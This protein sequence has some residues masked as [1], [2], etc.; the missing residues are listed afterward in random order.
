MN[1]PPNDALQ[2]T[3]SDK[4]VILVPS[5]NKSKSGSKRHDD[6]VLP[7]HSCLTKDNCHPFHDQHNEPY[8]QVLVGTHWETLRVKSRPMKRWLSKLSWEGRG[9]TVNEAEMGATIM[10][11]EALAVH[12]GPQKSLETRM[13]YLH[14]EKAILYDL[15]DPLWRAVRITAE[16]QSIVAEP[17]IYFR[18]FAH[19]SAQ[20]EP[21][22]GGDLRELLKLTNLA[23]SD[24]EML[25]LVYLVSC[26][27]PSIPHPV[28][29]IHGPQGSAKT[30]LAKMARMLVD[31]SSMGALSFPNNAREL[32]Q[33][34]SHNYMAF[35]DNVT[36]LKQEQSDAIC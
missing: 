13:F 34:L 11:V 2:E 26:L 23:D 7:L 33:L 8:A 30:T 1:V 5:L 31:P 15:T 10:H 19:Q 25:F 22:Q 32:V 6:K 17:G 27:I 18:R 28:P 20:V 24:Q 12:N 21:V 3:A 29:N 4:P 9:C 35:F 36:E 14:E 16:G